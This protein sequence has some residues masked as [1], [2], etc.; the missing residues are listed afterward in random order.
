MGCASWPHLPLKGA[1]EGGDARRWSQRCSSTCVLAF[2]SNIEQIA[3][4]SLS[5]EE[6]HQLAADGLPE[7]AKNRTKSKVRA[8]VEHPIGVIIEKIALVDGVRSSVEYGAREVDSRR[9]RHHY[10]YVSPHCFVPCPA[11]Q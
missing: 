3:S 7:R 5:P 2:V 6:F 8:R 9:A 10:L 11:V 4:A 1:F